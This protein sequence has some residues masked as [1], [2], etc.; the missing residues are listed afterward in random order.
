M[1]KNQLDMNNAPFCQE[2]CLTAD[3]M[4]T[5]AKTQHLVFDFTDTNFKDSIIAS[6]EAFV[7]QI[8]ADWCVECFIMSNL[9]NQLVE[10]YSTH[11]TFGFV[12]VDTTEEIAK[13]F[14]VTDLPFLLFF[15]H[16]ELVDFLI[17]L[18]SKRKIQHIIEKTIRFE[19]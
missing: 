15:N 4:A 10:D 6:G 8:R 12:N 11:V 5:I 13:D 9:I 2:H 3:D 7:I 17:G 19:K 18:Q 14:G 1:I 16:G